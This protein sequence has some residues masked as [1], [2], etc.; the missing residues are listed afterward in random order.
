[1]ADN[2]VTVY[3]NGE[4][5]MSGD[6]FTRSLRDM[7]PLTNEKYGMYLGRT[8]WQNTDNP[9]FKGLMD[10][11]RIY[12]RA[13]SEEEI[14]ELYL[15]TDPED[16]STTKPLTLIYMAEEIEIGRETVEVPR[17]GA[18]TYS[19]APA[20]VYGGKLYTAKAVEIANTA[21]LGSEYAVDMTDTPF[22]T[23]EFCVDAYVG[24]N[25]DLP[26]AA[27]LYYDGGVAEIPLSY[28]SSF[29]SGEAGVYTVSGEHN[30]ITVDVTVNVYERWQDSLGSTVGRASKVTVRFTDSSGE[31]I[32]EP[33]EVL[34]PTETSYTVTDKLLGEYPHIAN[35]VIPEPV[36]VT[37]PVH[38]INV[39]CEKRIGVFGVLSGDPG[40]G[41]LSA[42][43]RVINTGAADA[44]VMLIIAR[45]KGRELTGVKT[46]KITLP[47][48][49][50]KVIDLS[51]GLTYDREA[52]EDVRAYLWTS[53]LRPLDSAIIAS[54]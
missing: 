33:Y 40:E 21:A 9:D 49:S 51:V 12:N 1:A 11:V 45:Y 35:A 31:E 2:T 29:S 15:T 37:E 23:D 7:A 53:D 32:A 46:E 18:F 22:R 28:E 14:R 6:T 5:V 44:E 19:E 24:D 26:Q 10:E 48:N 20:I 47:A 17:S 42:S 27:K 43:A 8:M 16:A 38:E 4:P 52:G 30:G 25:A 54:E 34:V 36:T 39:A 13:I 3:V 41:A 50:V